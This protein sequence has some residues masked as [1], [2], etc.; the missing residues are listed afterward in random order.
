MTLLKE[1]PR[2]LFNGMSHTTVLTTSWDAR[3]KERERECVCVC[4]AC[5]CVCVHVCDELG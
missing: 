1:L 2:P 4:V 5:V 3:E